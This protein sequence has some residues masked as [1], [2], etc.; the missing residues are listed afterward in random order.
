MQISSSVIWVSG[1]LLSLSSQPVECDSETVNRDSS[2]VRQLG[3]LDF[4][5]RE[6][7]Q[8]D[9]LRLGVQVLPALRDGLLSNDL[10]I[11]HRCAWLIPAIEQAEWSRKAEA[12]EADHKGAHKHDLPLQNEY[13]NLVGTDPSARKLYSEIMRTNGTFLQRVADAHDRGRG[14]FERRCRELYPMWN[15]KA[16]ELVKVC[17]G[18]L[19]ALLLVGAVFKVDAVY[20]VDQP[21]PQGKRNHIVDLLGNPGVGEAVRS[22]KVGKAVSRLLVAWAESRDFLEPFF[23]HHFLFFVYTENFKEGLVVV[24]RVIQKESVFE[25]AVGIAVLAKVGGKDVADE[26]EMLWGDQRV[27]LHSHRMDDGEFRLGDQALAESM[28]S[29]GEDPTEFGMVDLPALMLKPGEDFWT[30]PVYGFV[31]DEDRRK[32]LKEWKDGRRLRFLGNLWS[33]CKA[34]LKQWKDREAR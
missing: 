28:R 6:A 10:E 24:R 9:L 14:A 11:K 17:S 13:E 22:K 3:S 15:H 5:I 20:H 7:A 8:W 34:L 16:Q 32:A 29:A 21:N 1:V 25:P 19:A 4:E 31:S 26:L 27:L 18:D 12:Y 33:G 23:L 2:L 30:V